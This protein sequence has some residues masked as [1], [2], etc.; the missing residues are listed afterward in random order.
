[1]R[2]AHKENRLMK[3]Q[4]LV[5]LFGEDKPG[6]VA[7]VTEL[8]VEN[9]ANLEES[10]MAILG[11]EFAAIMLVV[12]DAD[13]IAKLCQSLTK[14]SSEGI[15]TTCKQTKASQVSP[16][17]EA[18][19]V[20]LKGADHE[21]IVHTVAS[22]LREHHINIQALETGVSNAPE[23][24]TPLFSMFATL[25]VPSSVALNDLKAKL[26]EIATKE[27]VDIKLEACGELCKS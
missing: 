9:G 5:T 14:L 11:G 22:Y 16:G 20:S 24:G 12:A 17:H 19:T 21:G 23:T 13:K 27:S 15:H 4:L 18:F 25:Q 26:K 3:T 2:A 10:R 1:M 6:I 7:R 8:F